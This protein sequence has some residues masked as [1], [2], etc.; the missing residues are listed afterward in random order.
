MLS[1]AALAHSLSQL[2]LIQK[3]K[4]IW[5][6]CQWLHVWEFFSLLSCTS[7]TDIGGFFFSFFKSRH[8]GKIK[9]QGMAALD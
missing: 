5:F 3:G 6:Q 7:H 1:C 2:D 9:T 8:F 4:D